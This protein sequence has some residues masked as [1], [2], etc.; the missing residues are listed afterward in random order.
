MSRPSF[1]FYHGDWFSNAKLRRCNKDQKGHWIDILCLLADADEFGIL[2][3]PLAE[4]CEAVGGK[5]PSVRALVDKGVLKGA[6]KGQRCPAYIYTPRSGRKEGPPVTLIPEQEGPIWYSSKMVRDDYI[7]KARAAFARTK[8]QDDD[9]PKPAPNPGIGEAPNPGQSA[10]PPTPSP[11]PSPPSGKS[12]ST[13]QAAKRARAAAKT[14]L[15]SGFAISDRV[16]AWAA[17]KGF[18]R[19][20][21]HFENFVSKAKAKR[22]TYA[23][24]DEG[25]MGAIRADWA[26]LRVPGKGKEPDFSTLNYRDG[27]SEDGRF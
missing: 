24:W 23:D 6:D 9:A 13:P 3:W 25:F 8:G 21:A 27:V 2:R 4:I 22:Y 5:M 18:D 10:V 1:Q 17:E 20:E 16:R 11:S 12:E 15:P 14:T 26:S 7:A 19:L